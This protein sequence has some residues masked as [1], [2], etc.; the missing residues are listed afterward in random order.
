MKSIKRIFLLFFLAAGLTCYSQKKETKPRCFADELL[1]KAIEKNP[2]FKGQMDHQDDEIITYKKKHLLQKSITKPIII[3]VVIYVINTSVGAVENLTDIRINSQIDALNNYFQNSGI[4]FCIATKNGVDPIPTL[5]GGTQI[6]PGIIHITNAGLSTH[7][8][9]TE[10]AQLVATAWGLSPQKFLRIWVVKDIVENGVATNIGGYSMFPGQSIVFDGI[11]IKANVFGDINTCTNCPPGYNQGKTLAHEVGHYLNLHHTFYEGCAETTTGNCE[12]KGDRVCDTPPAIEYYGCSPGYNSCNEI[13]DLPDD[14][15]NFMAYGGDNCIN[16][17]TTGQN[18]RM[19]SAIN[20]YRSNLVSTDNL[21]FTGVCGSNNLLSATFDATNFSPCSGTTVTFSPLMTTGVTYSWNFGDPASGANNFSTLANP[22]HIYTTATSSPYNVTLTITDGTQTVVQTNFIYVNVCSP[23]QSTDDN[24]YF[25]STNGLTFNTGIPVYNDSAN[26][27]GNSFGEASAVQSNSSGQLLFYTSGVK[28]WN[29]AHVQINTAN[30]LMGHVSS[31]GGALI[32]PKPGSTSQYYIFTQDAESGLNGST[33]SIVNVTGTTATMTTT[34][35]KAIIPPVGQGFLTGNNGA[36]ISC[37][38]ITAIASCNGYWIITSGKKNT[39]YSII[40]YELTANE[41]KYVSQ[42]DLPTDLQT[43]W[44][45]I[46]SSPDGNKIVYAAFGYGTHLMDFNKKTGV[47]SNRIN[48]DQAGIYG[49]CFSPNSKVLYLGSFI[50]GFQY[51]LQVANPVATMKQLPD[52]VASHGE[53]QMGPDNKIYIT[54]STNLK[55][56]GVIHRPNEII[57]DGAN[58]CLVTKNGPVVQ[59]SL[60]FCLPNLINAKPSTAYN[61][62]IAYYIESCLTYRFTA[63][64]CDQT[65]NWSFG[66]PASGSNTSTLANPTHTFS[67]PGTYTV[68]LNGTINTTIIVGSIAPIISGSTTACV[69]NAKQTYHSTQIS[70]GQTVKWSIVSGSGS[71][72]TLSTQPDVIINWT[73]LPGTVRLTVTDVTG[74]INII[75]QVITEYCIGDQCAPNI[76]FDIPEAATTETYKVSNN[77]VTQNN[78]QV[79]SGKDISL[80]AANSIVMKTSTVIKNGSLLLAKIAPCVPA[81]PSSD[82]TAMEQPL[83]KLT[84][85]PNP[86]EGELHLSG[87]KIKEIYLFDV[88]GKDV[89]Y[90]KYDNVNTTTIDISGLQQ[91]LYFMKVVSDGNIIDTLKVI[92]D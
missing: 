11:V 43:P 51:D 63:N 68:T 41:L 65:F 42:L 46:K 91:G 64:V 13:N 23:I 86:T 49:T 58:N 8:V 82:R 26:L 59:N 39:G 19:Y 44:V 6:T 85:Y 21:I 29:N 20:L 24:W 52:Y 27:N 78:Y 10:Q 55:R 35:N 14:T 79:A 5:S 76:V 74:C 2:G 90:S 60:V 66:D 7:D 47:V 28:V 56:L 1:Q 12:T 72:T 62:T 34:V 80:I 75:E 31:H 92:K 45:L 4:Q 48:L 32:V 38:S 87:T 50:S 18:E 77:I 67:E 9:A 22:S 40:V 61:N 89:F 71:M 70:Q 15:T 36:L 25:G 33:Y 30:P 54:S 69:S 16:H 73:S 88:L 83:Q 57:T 81:R 37:E 3:P 53:M 84:V 17:F